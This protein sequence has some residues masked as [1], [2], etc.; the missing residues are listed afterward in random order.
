[1]SQ[2][3]FATVAGFATAD[4]TLRLTQG[5]A[6]VTHLRVACT[7][8]RIDRGTGEW[9]DGDTSYFSVTCWRKLAVAVKA[10]IRKG[11]PVLVRGRLRTRT[12]QKEERTVTE[13][14]ID[15]DA[16]G[17]DLTLGWSVFQRDRRAI[18]NIADQ[19]AAGE[20]ARQFNPEETHAATNPD[21]PDEGDPGAVSADADPRAPITPMEV[22]DETDILTDQAMAELDGELD[23]A[24]GYSVPA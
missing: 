2:E 4:P 20:A 21:D 8:R 5:G 3:A 22:S 15:A 12:W 19:V 10:S 23:E 13:I 16:M 7:P 14:E 18:P 9:K 6:E 17:H 11:D 1:M 24:A